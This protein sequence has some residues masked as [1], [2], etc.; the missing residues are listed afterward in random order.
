MGSW[1]SHRPSAEE[2]FGSGRGPRARGSPRLLPAAI[3]PRAL[4][5]AA[6]QQVPSTAASLLPP[7]RLWH[8]NQ[9]QPAGDYRAVQLAG[10]LFPV[11]EATSRPNVLFLHHS[12]FLLDFTFKTHAVSGSTQDCDTTLLSSRAA[13][14]LWVLKNTLIRAQRTATC[15]SEFQLRLLFIVLS[16]D[17]VLV[18]SC[19]WKKKF[20][21]SILTA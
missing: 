20:C 9:G 15:N 18:S 3:Q 21:G 4:P 13:T 6:P 8:I 19:T 17:I 2:G 14:K 16:R 7:E 1:S 11:T 12:G 10:S 5:Q